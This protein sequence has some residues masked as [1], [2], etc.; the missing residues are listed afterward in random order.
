MPITPCFDPTT[1]ASGGA[2]PAGGGGS[3]YAL[4]PTIVDLTDGSWT[5]FDP[6]SLIDSVAHSAGHNTVTFNALASGS[7]NYNWSA[8]ATIRAPRWFRKLEISG[9]QVK[10]TDSLNFTTQ[11]QGDLTVN[12]FSRKVV[13][14]PAFDPTS[15]TATVIQGTGGVHAK[16]VGGPAAQ[17]GIWTV[18]SET[19]QPNSSQVYG[20]ST[21]MRSHNCLGGGTYIGVDSGGVAIGQGSRNANVLAAT[22]GATLD[23]YVMVGVG[24]RGSGDT[25]PDNAE[26]KFAA[27]FTA[28]TTV[29]GV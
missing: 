17:Y 7:T 4:A 16:A 9:S 27:K 6:D 21:V 26:F 29:F 18:N 2:A 5:L 24:T 19:T 14:G 10:S 3:L 28:I 13:C 22:G 8:G 25:I 23:V 11:L 20:L 12:D 15:V 1:G